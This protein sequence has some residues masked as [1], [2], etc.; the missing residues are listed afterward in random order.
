[1]KVHKRRRSFG[2][3]RPPAQSAKCKSSFSDSWCAIGV[4]LVDTHRF[5]VLQVDIGLARAVLLYFPTHRAGFGLIFEGLRDSVR[6]LRG[7]EIRQTSRVTRP[8]YVG[9]RGDV[10]CGKRKS[11]IG[12]RLLRVG[13]CSA[14]TVVP[15]R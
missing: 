12:L 14:S 9:T 6:A 13:M 5:I 15:F 2:G 3:I 8:N 7:C 1:M 4:A 11:S 10:P